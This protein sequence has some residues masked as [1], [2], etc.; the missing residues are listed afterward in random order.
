VREDDVALCRTTPCAIFYD[1]AGNDREASHVLTIAR[2]GYRSETRR[3][4]AAESPVTVTLSPL[5]VQVPPHPRR[6]KERIVLSG[7]RLDAY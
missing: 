3:V 7:Y 5:P 4:T 2:E 1:G 6:D